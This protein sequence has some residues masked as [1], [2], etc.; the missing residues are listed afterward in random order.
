MSAEHPLVAPFKGP[1][2]TRKRLVTML[3]DCYGPS[4]RGAVNVSGVADYLNV[5]TSTVRRWLAGGEAA[6]RRHPPIPSRRLSQLQCGPAD[7][8]RRSEHQYRYA[9]AAISDIAAGKLVIPYWR[10]RGWLAEHT[11][12]ILEL[13]R[14]PWYQ[15]AFTKTKSKQEL[16]KRGAIVD[17]IVVP[18]QFHAR[19]LVHTVM[20]ALHAWRVHPAPPRLRI[21]RTQVWM[22]DAPPVDLKAVAATWG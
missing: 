21:G 15:I 14:Q 20:L 13:R 6:N 4:P 19:V 8:E 5:S 1:R 18:T 7:V 22:N 17:S 12:A 3:I 2:W 11:V 9:L 10:E 16:L